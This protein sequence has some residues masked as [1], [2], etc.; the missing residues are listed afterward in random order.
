[1]HVANA[2]R[3]FN[4]H[5]F[6]T[7]INLFHQGKFLRQNEFDVFDQE[8]RRRYR[9][10]VFLFDRSIVFAE[11]LEEKVLHY[12]G[13]YPKDVTGIREYDEGKKFDLFIG[14]SGNRQI[15]LSSNEFGL[16]QAWVNLVKEMLVKSIEQG[17]S[18]RV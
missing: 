10:K 1:M 17:K 16:I 3:P 9:G 13:N 18:W 14:K 11:K 2:A 4:V 8:T 15:E 6:I 7:Q 12:R 5:C